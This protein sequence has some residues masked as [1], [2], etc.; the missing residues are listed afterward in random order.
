[1]VDTAP[2]VEVEAEVEPTEFRSIRERIRDADDV[3]YKDVEVPEWGVTLRLFSMNGKERAEFFA[4]FQVEDASS[5]TDEQLRD[6]LTAMTPA[7]LIVTAYD[8]AG[9]DHPNPSFRVFHDDDLDWLATKNSG[10]TERLGAVALK[11]SG[12]DRDARDRAGKG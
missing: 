3:N 2:E 7:L 6:R 10:I 5:E 1:M 12:L 4:P 11:L 9:G 8:P